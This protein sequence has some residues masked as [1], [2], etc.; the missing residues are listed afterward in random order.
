MQAQ[1]IIYVIDIDVNSDTYN[2]QVQ[3]INLNVATGNIQDIAI[4]K[5]GDRL[6]VTDYTGA[7]LRLS[8]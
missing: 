2:Q 6:F 3:N 5:E 1:N 4:N 7:G 8:S